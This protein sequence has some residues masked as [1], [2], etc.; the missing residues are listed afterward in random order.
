MRTFFNYLV[1]G[2]LT[3]TICAC[4]KT[5]DADSS[6]SMNNSLLL[7]AYGD[8]KDTQTKLVKRKLA[9]SNVMSMQN[10]T[11]E[12]IDE[13]IEKMPANS[14]LYIMADCSIFGDEMPQR[15]F[16]DL[17]TFHAEQAEAQTVAKRPLIWLVH[18]TDA[19]QAFRIFGID[20]GIGWYLMMD[21]PAIPKYIIESNSLEDENLLKYLIP[22]FDAYDASQSKTRASSNSDEPKN[23]EPFVKY[24][25][26][27]YWGVGSHGDLVKGPYNP[28][29]ILKASDR[30]PD[31][32]KELTNAASGAFSVDASLKIE[33]FYMPGVAEKLIKVTV[34]GIG[35]QLFPKSSLFDVSENTILIQQG[36]YLGPL[37][38][39]YQVT[40]KA[41]NPTSGAITLVNKMPADNTNLT[42]YQESKTE[43]ENFNAGLS[44]SKNGITG[45]LGYTYVC[46]SATN[47]SYEMKDMY[48][49]PQ[50]VPNTAFSTGASWRF[51]PEFWKTNHS[52]FIQSDKSNSLDILEAWYAGDYWG[53]NQYRILKS[54]KQGSE[55]EFFYTY[56]KKKPLQMKQVFRNSDE[57][58]QQAYPK[59]NLLWNTES[60]QTLLFRVNDAKDASVTLHVDLALEL[61]ATTLSYHYN[62]YYLHM[63]AVDQAPLTPAYNNDDSKR[64]WNKRTVGY[65]KKIT[66][67]FNSKGAEV[68]DTYQTTHEVK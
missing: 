39:S 42:K 45:N 64:G 26:Y 33:T 25:R 59:Q 9:L 6:A 27:S 67:N 65:E 31:S 52:S 62:K 61:Q 66:I 54:T 29:I 51:G 24:V 57:M 8:A 41:S 43:T 7:V 15:A 32:E 63:G 44:I 4:E 21:D 22:M 19:E 16:D 1:C 53:D 10:S 40:V 47:F 56:G 18:V 48:Y 60:R 14:P 68:M 50:A 35:Y 11:K 36:C 5:D 58:L 38:R 20:M 46:S 23:L 49:A 2:L 13:A 55:V 30:L 17:K 12:Q 37:L 34:E 3:F 28:D